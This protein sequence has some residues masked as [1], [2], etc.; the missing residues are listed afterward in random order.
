M[1]RL[2]AAGVRLLLHPLWRLT[3]GMT[4]G[5]RALVIDEAGAVLLVEHGYMPGWH[6]PGGGVEHCETVGDALARELAEEAAVR[7]TAA[8][9]LFGLYSN[10]ELMRGDHV[11]LYVVRAFE[12]IAARPRRYEILRTGFYAVDGLPDGTTP[13]TRRRID[14]VLGG[15]APAAA[16]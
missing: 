3:R 8:P 10:F 14:E 9:E 16:W 15:R 7:A 5:V 12:P 4:L 13:G 6:L 11:A 1:R 2:T